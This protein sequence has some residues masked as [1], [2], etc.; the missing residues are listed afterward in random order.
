MGTQS[1]GRTSFGSIANP[2]RS[3][4]GS[5]RRLECITVIYEWRCEKCEKV[6]A[7]SRP[8]SEHKRGPDAIEARHQGCDSLSF[9]RILSRPSRINVPENEDQ[10]WS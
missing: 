1:M 2:Q 7:V 8:V 5:V 10:Y 3:G 6:V 4:L 9:K